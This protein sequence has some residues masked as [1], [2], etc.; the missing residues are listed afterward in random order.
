MHSTRI[1]PVQ[2]A[3]LSF[4]TEELRKLAAD[5][6][7]SDRRTAASRVIPRLRGMMVWFGA[8][9]GLALHRVG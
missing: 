6:E 9:L 2:M 7:E 4:L 3:C 1:D 5:R 8:L